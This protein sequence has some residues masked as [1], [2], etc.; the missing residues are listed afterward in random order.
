MTHDY[1]EYSN[2]IYTVS[3]LLS[4]ERCA[5][6]IALS[7]QMGYNSAPITTERGFEIKQNIRNNTRVIL[8]SIELAEEFWSLVEPWV[9]SDWRTCK[10]VGL[11][12]RFRFYRYD[13]GQ[14]FDWHR[15]GIYRRKN[16]Q[17]SL[18]T[19]IFYLNAD[20][21]GGLTEF[22]DLEIPIEAGSALFFWHSELH[23]GSPV[24]AGR[25]YVLRT[26]VMYSPEPTFKTCQVSDLP[27]SLYHG[28]RHAWS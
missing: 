14:Q 13:S 17:K 5:E 19:V 21:D 15:D 22:R 3:N 1:I 27:L 11:N 23:R 24:T 12:E 7:E 10:A 6:L 18:F 28:D 8:D 20:F 16:G 25:K 4:E 9:V 2:S 26:D